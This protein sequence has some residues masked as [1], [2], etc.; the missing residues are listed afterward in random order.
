MEDR[1][2]PARTPSP[3]P[4]AEPREDISDGLLKARNPDLYY[5][6]SHMQCYH[7]CQQCEDHCEIAES[8]GHKRVLFAMF[9][10]MDRILHCWQQYKTRTKRSRAALLSW[11]EFKTF[12]RQSLGESDTFVG[13]V[14]S[15]MRSNSQHQLEEV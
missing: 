4:L 10:L 2:N 5:G 15:K 9:F 7:F 1:R 12:L 6:N 3:A 14:W 13:N 8:K 11:E